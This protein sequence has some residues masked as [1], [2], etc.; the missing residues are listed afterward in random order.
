MTNITKDDQPE[1]S[2]YFPPN[3]PD[4]ALAIRLAVLANKCDQGTTPWQV[5]EPDAPTAADR[6]ALAR[7]NRQLKLGF[8]PVGEREMKLMLATFFTGYPT[9]R[10]YDEEQANRMLSVYMA[11]LRGKP[12]WAINRMLQQLTHEGAT[13]LHPPSQSQMAQ[14]TDAIMEPFDIESRTIDAVLGVKV[15]QPAHQTLTEDER[16]AFADLHWHSKPL[17][18]LTPEQQK[19]E[20]ERRE[21][22][23][24]R[25][26]ATNQT[27]FER[28][29][30]AAGITDKLKIGVELRRSLVEKM[31]AN[32]GGRTGI[33]DEYT[34]GQS[35]GREGDRAD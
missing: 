7:R 2:T 32:F 14:V 31:K 4:R 11:A 5:N 26:D 8:G 6:D 1:P 19:E 30:R 10:F 16:V 23:R 29:I 25:M 9:L 21:A 27:F 20:N 34:D 3:P 28:G 17:N 24:I 18:G 15:M 22:A 12:A 33:G 35:G 13:P